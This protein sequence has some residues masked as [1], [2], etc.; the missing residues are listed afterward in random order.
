MKAL[1][2]GEK[3]IFIGV[4]A[5]YTLSNIGVNCVVAKL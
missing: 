1:I 2:Y 4:K 5:I 3:G